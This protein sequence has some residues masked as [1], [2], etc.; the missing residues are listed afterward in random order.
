MKV[1]VA[2]RGEIACRILATLRQRG[3]P[4]VALYTDLDKGAPHVWLADEAL[5]L[6]EPTGYLQGQAIVN[7]AKRLGVTAVHP[8]YGFLSQN[9][10]FARQCASAGIN[11]I[12]P[13]PAAMES[14]GDKR[15]ARQVAER[16]GVPVVPGATT[17]DTVDQARAAVERLGVPVLLKAAGGGGGK[18]MRRVDDPKDL[19]DAFAAAQREAQNA[20]ADGRLLV[21]RYIHPA[22]HVEVQ[23]LGDGK[24][25]VALGERECSL[26]RR[27]Q[28][29]IEEAPAA[30]LTP[31]QRTGLHAA[32]VKV[33]EAVGYA[34]AGT[35][36]FLVGPDGAY[37]FLEVNTRLQVEHP[38]TEL[39]IGLDLVGAQIDVAHGGALPKPPTPRGH[40]MEAR[41]NAED[42]YGGFLPAV[43]KVLMLQWPQLP[44]VRVDSGLV[45]GLEITPAYDPMLAKVI[46]W[47]D[48]REAARLRLRDALINTTLL[49]LTTNQAFLIDLLQRDFFV[50]GQTFTT[51]VEATSWT[52][53]PLPEYIASVAAQAGRQAVGGAAASSGP[54]DRYSPWDSL[55]AFRMGTCG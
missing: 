26:Q 3:I 41:L 16:C 1:L 23:I 46:A 19:A 49:G 32:A 29:I 14:L 52:A 33:A 35:V 24:K 40:A 47:G 21:E 15:A 25:A 8:G 42:A 44:N 12:G 13:S 45:E 31:E 30:S 17:C 2:N 9:P 10:G 37:Y 4:S 36:E 28:K 50:K 34:N 5:P 20:F 18:G 55:G 39:L 22:R 27:Y 6:G 54:A 38:I 7:G 48:S 51:T 53:P 43:G 11:F